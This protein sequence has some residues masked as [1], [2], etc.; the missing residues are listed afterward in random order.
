MIVRINQFSPR[1]RLLFG[2]AAT[3]VVLP[4]PGRPS[5]GTTDEA[6]P[7][8]APICSDDHVPDADAAE[9]APHEH[10]PPRSDDN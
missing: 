5:P 8:T 7:S 2:I 10:I 4:D 9:P 1:K 6:L 3:A